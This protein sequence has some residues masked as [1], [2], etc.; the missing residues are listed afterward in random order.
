L[1]RQDAK[2]EERASRKRLT[3]VLTSRPLFLITIAFVGGIVCAAQETLRP[4][5]GLVV[6]A[7]ILLAGALIPRKLVPR[8]IIG[9]VAAVFIIGFVRT[10]CWRQ[11][12]P[13]DIS[14]Y[15]EGKLVYLTGTV[16]S[17]LEPV[18][19]NIHF[20]LRTTGVKNYVGEYPASGNVMVTLYRSSFTDDGMKAPSYGEV[21]RIHGR[22]RNPPEPSNPGAFD[23]ST[24]LARKRVFCVLSANGSELA[25]V[26]TPTWNLARLG[27]SFKQVLVSRA[28]R[29]FPPV[30][31]ALLLGILLGNYAALPLHIQGAFMRSG[32]M[33]LL[34]A[35]GYNCAVIVGIFGWIL[36]RLTTPRVVTHWVLI[37]LLWG[38][39]LVVGASPSIVRAAVMVTAFL[40]AY[41]IWRAADMVNLVLFAGLVIL[42][43]NPMSLYDVGFQLSFSAVLGI[44]LLMPLVQKVIHNWLTATWYADLKPPS[45]FSRLVL[46]G[47]QDIVLALALSIVAGLWTVPITMYYFNY[48]STVSILANA[49][50]ALLVVLLTAVGIAALALGA[51]WLPLGHAAAV[52]GTAITEAMLR[53]V[54]GLGNHPWSSLSVPSPKP[55]LL[56]VYYLVLLGVSDY[57]YRKAA[58]TQGAAGDTLPGARRRVN[59]VTGTSEKA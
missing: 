11:T 6:T 45:R 35:S 5:A 59:L 2:G 52:L 15:A 58:H 27:A 57:A 3:T 9:M 40:I 30:H 36:H 1:N 32:T 23:Y 47:A 26:Q 21:I 48:L 56:A 29:L 38:F 54:V 20:V 18:G 19:N 55:I 16:A 22:L 46:Y 34:A 14:Q 25:V 12:P 53:I 37:G 43:V 13:G 4:L 50:V 28:S 33:H 24:Y 10:A 8:P 51:I 42:G 41:L 44:V 39:T 31:S 17:D 7:G 49:L